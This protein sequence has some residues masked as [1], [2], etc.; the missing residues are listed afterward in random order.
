MSGTLKVTGSGALA[1]SATIAPRSPRLARIDGCR[2]VASSRRSSIAARASSS[3]P[4]TSGSPSS[5]DRRLGERHLQVDDD[6]DQ[7][8]LRAV[9]QVAP[10]APPL[11]VR[12]LDEAPA[13]RCELL[14]VRALGLGLQPRLLG[15]KPR[16]HVAEH[17]DR[18]TPLGRVERRRRVG[19]RDHRAIAPDE[20]VVVDLHRLARLARSQQRAL[21]LRIR[22]AVAVVG[23]DRAVALAP[24][25]LRRVVVAQDRQP[26]GVDELDRAVVCHDV[27]AVRNAREQGR[28]EGR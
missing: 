10:E 18:A 26:G 13:R 7:P 22:R 9:V 24:E 28:Q 12:R 23:M 6:V 4:A 19:H 20:P 27:H 1:V 8:L 21:L 17:H 2:P 3:A 15:A 14:R 25:Q 11:G 5:R 16:G